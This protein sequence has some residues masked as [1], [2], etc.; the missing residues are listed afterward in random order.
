M[1]VRRRPPPATLVGV[2]PGDTAF[3]GL[4]GHERVCGLL[5]RA[6]QR[7]RLHHGLLLVGPRGVGKSTLARGLGC[8]LHC[9]VQPGVGCGECV[10]CR[11]VLDD[12]HTD[13]VRIEPKKDSKSGTIDT[14][15][16]K[17]LATSIH[18]AP[19]E[20][21]AHLVIIKP[22][23]KLYDNAANALLKAIEE[24]PPG[25][26]FALLTSNVRGVL[27]TIQSRCIELRL[28]G[29]PDEQVAE[30][31]DRHVAERG[32]SLDPDRRRVAIEL[33]QGSPGE[34]IKLAT[35]EGLDQL[36]AVLAA[37][38]RAADE[39]PVAVFAGE[40]SR[41]WSAWNEAVR[42]LPFET[43]EEEEEAV[44][45]VRGKKPG[46][47]R[48]KKPKKPK[49]SELKTPARQRETAIR[50]TDLWLLH[51]RER[52]RGRPGLADV[53]TT[54]RESSRDLTRS[55]QIVQGLQDSIQQNPNV[56]LAL[57][58]ALLELSA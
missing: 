41:L 17:A 45:V 9:P 3:P 25:V 51:L 7:G 36:R 44:V 31:L 34:A 30:V 28:S 54:R 11:R 42:S 49:D 37:A 14:A 35:D 50:L 2:E 48:K 6:I 15:S 40:R 12:H 46:G 8:A 16:A 10:Q 13:V 26:H 53:P 27:P 18:N 47:A 4:V 58:Q 23:D 52:L 32:L 20:S 39:G 22:A 33:A 38:V 1:G 5:T 21:P 19:Y 43:E 29:L 24:P 55:I 57:E 56:R